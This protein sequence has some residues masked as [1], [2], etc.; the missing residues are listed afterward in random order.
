MR[1]A[2]VSPLPPTRSGIADYSAELLAALGPAAAIELF[3]S[4]PAD[5]ARCAPWPLYPLAAFPDRAAD[6]DLV[7][8]HIGNNQHHVGIYDLALRHPGVVVLHDYVLHHLVARCTI[9][10]GDLEGYVRHLAYERGPAGA[11]AGIRRAHGLFT[12]REQFLTPLNRLLLDRSRGVVVHSRW[13]AEEVRRRHPG[14]PVRHIL[15]HRAPPPPDR[16]DEFR[17]QLGVRPDEL[18]LATFGFLTPYK[19]VDTLL[20]AYARLAREYPHVRCFL[21]GEPAPDLDLPGL[22]AR[23]GLDGRVTLTGYLDLDGFYSYIA[24]CDIAVNLRY[25]SAGETS[26]TLVR[27]LGGG[28][29]VIISNLQQFAEWPDDICLKVDPGP[30]QPAMLLDYLRRLVQDPALRARLGANARRYVASHHALEQ[31]ARGYQEFFDDLL[32]P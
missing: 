19:G 21:V 29:A 15:H 18:V 23:N 27:L 20:W 10:R 2:W 7:V 12:E 17:R 4:H 25:P 32:H 9:L 22:L 6:C 26:G 11:A 3:A 5:P 28:K 8:Y 30:A 31:S 1:L 16:R 14:T 13:A 24:A